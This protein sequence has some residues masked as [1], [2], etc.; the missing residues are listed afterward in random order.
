MHRDLEKFCRMAKTAQDRG[1]KTLNMDTQF[2]TRV[3]AAI[4]EMGEPTVVT[5]LPSDIQ[6]DSGKF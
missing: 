3:A 5:K 1:V 4:K 2:L 6:V